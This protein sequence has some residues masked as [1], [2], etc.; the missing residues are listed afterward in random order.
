MKK[1]WQFVY[2]MLN[3]NNTSGFGYDSDKQCVTVEP[4]VWETYI[5][6]HK[7][8]GKWRNKSFPHFEDL[9]I[10]F[11]KDKAQGNG[12]KDYIEMEGKANVKEESQNKVQSEEGSSARSKKRKSR[13]DLIVEG[14]TN[15]ATLLGKE[16][17]EA[18]AI[19]NESLKAE[20]DLQ[21]K[22]SLVSSEISKILLMTDMEKF[23]AS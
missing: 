7:G 15:A 12:T 13:F 21:N 6:V 19:M 1:D 14:V 22:T 11:G 8:A 17:R 18:L 16:L 2:D 3:G 9:C 23:R 5:A 4:N 20:V 10:I